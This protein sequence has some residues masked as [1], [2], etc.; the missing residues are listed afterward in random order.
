METKEKTVAIWFVKVD[1]RDTPIDGIDWKET[2]K[3]VLRDDPSRDSR[4]HG[5]FKLGFDITRWLFVQLG[6][7]RVD[8]T[9][10]SEGMSRRVD[11]V[12]R[13][14]WGI[15]SW[16]PNLFELELS[17][18]VAQA[19]AL[20][21]HLKYDDGK[22]PSSLYDWKSELVTSFARPCSL[23]WLR[24]GKKEW[25]GERNEALRTLVILPLL[26]AVSR[27]FL[28]HGHDTGCQW[29]I[30]L[31]SSGYGGDAWKNKYSGLTFIDAE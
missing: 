9:A 30:E 4:M 29:L 3:E 20:L 2:L 16:S 8:N 26:R 10:L 5:A 21:F 15:Y 24:M 28:G 6:A 31:A 14:A 13:V 27:F 7:L 19:E 23:S 12:L 25:D 18:R 22:T 17:V 1:G 11:E